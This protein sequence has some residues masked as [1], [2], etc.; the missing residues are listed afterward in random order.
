MFILFF[1]PSIEFLEPENIDEE[2][3]DKYTVS[4]FGML[5]Y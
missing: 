3:M 2:I 5:L 4:A 1:K